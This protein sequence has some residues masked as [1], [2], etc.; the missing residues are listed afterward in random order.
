M[1]NKAAKFL[2]PLAAVA[3]LAAACAKENTLSTGQKA[4]AQLTDWMKQYHKGI[5]A[6]ASGLY[7]LEDTPGTGALWNAGTAFTWA[8]VTIRSLSGTVSSTTE[9]HWARQLGTYSVSDYYGPQYMQ[10]GENVSYAGVDAMLSGMRIGGTRTA[11]IPAWLLTTS[12]YE[13]TQEY[14]DNCSSTSHAIYTIRLAGQVEDIVKMEADSLRSYVTRH[15]GAAQQSTVYTSDLTDD[16]SFYFV[17]D[18]T[19]FVNATPISQDTTLTLNYTGRLLNG[20][21]F[22]TTDQRTAKDAGIYDASKTYEP[23]SVKYSK[24][25]SN[26]TLD[27]SSVIN[28]FQGGISLMRWKGQK[29]VVLF[30]SAHGYSSSGGSS[31]IPPY[32]PLLFEL[33]LVKE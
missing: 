15:Y 1:N 28:G 5:S 27:G 29:A 8:N 13:T 9:E 24:T 23:V 12:R 3:C 30:S 17:S 31:S 21:V 32:S 6:D 33:E 22:D 25:Y 18:S 16:G 26:V 7:I 14:L 20:R 4:Q 19:A 2:L 10:S 11:V